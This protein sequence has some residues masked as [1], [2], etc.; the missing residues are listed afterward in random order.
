[1]AT[2]VM[3]KAARTSEAG[4]VTVGHRK[5]IFHVLLLKVL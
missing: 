4:P 3:T 1:M 2:T 5:L